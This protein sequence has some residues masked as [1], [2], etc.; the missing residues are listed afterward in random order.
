[1]FRK[2]KS[3]PTPLPH[4]YVIKKNQ[5]LHNIFHNE[6]T[7]EDLKD[8]KQTT[9]IGTKYYFDGGEQLKD[10]LLP[11]LIHFGS[12]RNSESYLKVDNK[13]IQVFTQSK[14]SH[15][16]N[17]VF[18]NGDTVPKDVEVI[19]ENHQRYVRMIESNRKIPVW[20]KDAFSHQQKRDL[21]HPVL[22]KFILSHI[23]NINNMTKNPA[24]SIRHPLSFF[25]KPSTPA[26]MRD[27]KPAVL[28]PL[29]SVLK[30]HTK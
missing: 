15:E 13:L 4:S 16:Q 2:D 1:M 25:G 23:S 28:P 29:S 7:L 30:T 17:L 8:K 24:A 26:E 5:G 19:T 27:K 6:V 14:I 20:P 18:R 9:R 11:D 21:K 3:I 12:G 10:E 22:A